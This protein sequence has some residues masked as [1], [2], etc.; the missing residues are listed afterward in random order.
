[1]YREMANGSDITPYIVSKA[2]E[3]GDAVA[4]QIFKQIG[5]Y[6]GIGLSSVINLLN[7]EKV[8]IGGGVSAAGALLFDPIR[9]TINER[10]MKIAREAVEIVPAELG[11]TAGVIGAS[12]LMDS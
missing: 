12:L 9:E 2:A 6:I 11:N 1:M 5:H 7:P 10:A 4:R 8:I 3:E